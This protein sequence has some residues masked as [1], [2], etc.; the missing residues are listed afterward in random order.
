MAT[1]RLTQRVHGF[2]RRICRSI[3][4]RARGH[5]LLLRG[6]SSFKAISQVWDEIESGW[7]RTTFGTT[8]HLSMRD[9]DIFVE[10]TEREPGRLTLVADSFPT[11]VEIDRQTYKRLL[12]SA[13]AYGFWF[14]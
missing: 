14:K 6:V 4:A 8:L 1:S 12:K 7:G 5:Y 3:H 11:E 9:R 2:A 13:G 10:A